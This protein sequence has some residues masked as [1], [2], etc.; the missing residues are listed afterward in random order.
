MHI[1]EQFSASAK[2]DK[3]E[4]LIVE[5]PHFFGVF[6]G[7]GG[8]K[9][10]W[11]HE[12]RTMGQ[13]AAH[14]AGEA[15]KELPAEAGIA[16]YAARAVARVAA[17]KQVMGL[18]AL[19]RLASGAL[20][21][22]RRRRLEVWVIGDSHFG[23]RLKDGSWK[24]CPQNKLYDALVL[25]YRQVVIRQE[26]AERGPPQSKEERAAIVAPAAACVREA[27]AKQMLW[28]N[29]PDPDEKL[30][31]GVIFGAPIPAHHQLRYALPEDVAEIVLCSDGLPEVVPTAAEGRAAIRSLREADPFLTGNNALGFTG[32]KGGFVQADGSIAD[33]YDD[34]SYLRIGL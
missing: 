2:G 22:P 4:D 19:D 12:G 33:W 18:D 31:F 34:V 26:L 1:I 24:S 11:Q 21:L 10:G 15:L 30:G 7:V 14:L 6:D 13:W 29:H 17:A 9:P 20:I 32:Y 8:V 16:D 5:T 28:A 27:L 25:G 23:Y 3:T